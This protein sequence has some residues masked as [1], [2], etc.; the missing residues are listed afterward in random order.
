MSCQDT[1][2]SES[3]EA[4]ESEFHVKYL[5]KADEKKA[6]K[7]WLNL[8]KSHHGQWTSTDYTY[9]N[10]AAYSWNWGPGSQL[11]PYLTFNAIENV[12]RP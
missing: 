12:S 2:N 4:F 6:G 9:L 3:E 7:I 8:K 11:Q 5:N 1:D 10:I